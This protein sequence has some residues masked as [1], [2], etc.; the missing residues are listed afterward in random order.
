MGAGDGSGPKHR[1]ARQGG[2]KERGER[3]FRNEHAVDEQRV[4]HGDV[5]QRGLTRD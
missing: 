5:A 1:E 4:R 3:E 2:G